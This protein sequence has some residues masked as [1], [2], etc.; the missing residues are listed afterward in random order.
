MRVSATDWI[1]VLDSTTISAVRYD[2]RRQLLDIR[3]TNERVYRYVCVTEF[4]YRV[5]MRSESKGRYFNK[6]IRDSFDYD[7]LD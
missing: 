1:E 7:E 4:V 6:M 5:L 2:A 3:F